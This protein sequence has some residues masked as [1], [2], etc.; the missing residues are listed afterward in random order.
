MNFRHAIF[1]EFHLN[2]SKSLNFICYKNFSSGRSSKLEILGLS[3]GASIKEI[4]SAYLK[5]SKELHPDVNDS[6]DAKIKYQ[7]IRNA[8][9]DLQ[10]DVSNSTR[11]E[12]QT[13]TEDFHKS[14]DYYQW[15]RRNKKQKD[16]DEW[17]RHVQ[18]EAR[19][20]EFKLKMK[21]MEEK[22]EHDPF[23][24]KHTKIVLEMD[25]NYLDFE[26]KFIDRLDSLISKI[27]PSMMNKCERNAAPNDWGGKTREEERKDKSE[28]IFLKRLL[29]PWF[30]RRS[31]SLTSASLVIFAVTLSLL[32]NFL[33]IFYF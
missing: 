12:G 24:G 10:S 21:A 8:Y 30:V 26:K 9:D 7:Q 28:I 31:L 17:L 4:K 11:E 14:K 22:E 2:R 5:L 1:G 33:H 6:I 3:E 16:L 19:F 25:Q 32:G 15:R 13:H 29:L 27:R 18:R 20:R 23:W